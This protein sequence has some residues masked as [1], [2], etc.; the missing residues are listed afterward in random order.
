MP[1]VLVTVSVL[2]PTSVVVPLNAIGTLMAGGAPKVNWALFS[3]SAW[4][5]VKVSAW[6]A[7]SVTVPATV[8]LPEPMDAADPRLIVPALRLVLPVM[9]LAAFR[10]TT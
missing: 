9:L 6:T 2:L 8:T 7:P 4:L 3:V 1:P 10:V 5:A